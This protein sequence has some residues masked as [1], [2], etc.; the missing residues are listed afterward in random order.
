MF[1]L[2][3]FFNLLLLLLACLLPYLTVKMYLLINDLHL[4]FNLNKLNKD[5]YKIYYKVNIIIN[6]KNYILDNLIIS[7]FGIFIINTKQFSTNVDKDEIDKSILNYFKPFLSY[8]N[9]PLIANDNYINE[10]SDYL[11]IDESLIKFYTCTNFG[12]QYNVEHKGI[13]VDCNN[14]VDI[15]YNHYEIVINDVN[16]IINKFN[17]K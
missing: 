10:L 8:Y 13:K 5:V 14:I 12:P 16:E 17:V 15:I 7:P 9:N 2:L 1:L 4:K 11:N 3:L 6:N